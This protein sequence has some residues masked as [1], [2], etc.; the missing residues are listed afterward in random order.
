MLRTFAF[1]PVRPRYEAGLGGVAGAACVAGAAVFLGV[2]A[3]LMT[4][5]SPVLTVRAT[6]VPA[7]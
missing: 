7:T 6:I 3:F 1:L 4:W 2:N 5:M